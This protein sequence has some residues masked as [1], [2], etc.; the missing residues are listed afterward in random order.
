MFILDLD[1]VFHSCTGSGSSNIL[2]LDLDPVNIL[3]SDLDPVNILFLY[4]ENILIPVLDQ[5]NILCFQFV[6]PIAKDVSKGPECKSLINNPHVCVKNGFLVVI[7]CN[8]KQ[9][10][11][12]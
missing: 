10:L 2:I 7:I 9:A 1:P 4:L 3:L 11:N 6:N 8:L 5:L 12:G